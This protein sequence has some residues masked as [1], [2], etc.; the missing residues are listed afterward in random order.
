MRYAI[1][2][3][4]SLGAL[5]L[6]IL[7]VKRL[8]IVPGFVTLIVSVVPARSRF[9]VNLRNLALRLAGHFLPLQVI[10]TFAPAGTALSA[11]RL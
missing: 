6:R 4:L 3:I 10:E 9:F 5:P 1:C 11:R 8:P 2:E 7:I